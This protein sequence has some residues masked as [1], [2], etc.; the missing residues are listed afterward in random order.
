MTLSRESNRRSRID[1][2]APGMPDGQ[3]MDVSRIP[4]QYWRAFSIL[5][6]AMNRFIVDHVIRSAR[7]FDNDTEA[8]ILFGMLAHLNIVHLVPP[9]SSPSTTLNS[10]GRIPDSRERLRPVRLRDLSQI[11]G[12]P[13]ETIRRKLEQMRSNGLV[14]RFSKGRKRRRRI[15]PAWG[16][17]TCGQNVTSPGKG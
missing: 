6:F 15:G 7:L 16:M 14:L 17:R 12:R 8:L 11:T 9:G 3:A 4:Q 5:A 10:D 13:R 1:I 2:G